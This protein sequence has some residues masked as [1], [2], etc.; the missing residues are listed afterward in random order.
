MYSRNDKLVMKIIGMS[1]IFWLP[2]T[3]TDCAAV[4]LIFA[5][6]TLQTIL[7]IDDTFFYFVYGFGDVDRLFQFHWAFDI[8]TLDAI[9]GAIV[10][11]V[12]CWRIW[13]LS[14]WR[15][16]PMFSLLVSLHTL[17]CKCPRINLF[18]LDFPHG[19]CIGVRCG[20]FGQS[21]I[22]LPSRKPVPEY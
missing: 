8:P 22:T 4:H 12:Y 2:T 17:A 10:Q 1:L 7:S 5:L 15:V 11:V 20:S 16:V 6:D 3:H 13:M 18:D 19:W 14:G 9:V 21:S